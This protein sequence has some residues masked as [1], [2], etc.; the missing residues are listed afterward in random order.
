MRFKGLVSLLLLLISSTCAANHLPH[1]KQVNSHSQLIVNGQPFIMLGG[2]LGNSSATSMEY[3]QPIWPKLKTMNINTVL[4]PVYWEMIEPTPGQFDFSSLDALIGEARKQQQKLVLLWF[5]AWKNSMSS[6]APGWIKLDQ[7][8][9]PRI[10]DENGKS[11][12]ILTPFS[13]NVLDADK[14]AF[15]ALMQ[16]LKTTDTQQNTVIMVQVENEIGMLPSARDHHPLANAKFNAAVPA[17]LIHYLQ[18]PTA[19]LAPEL[20]KAWQKQ[21]NKTSG[22]WEKI[23]GKSKQTDEF[24][25]AWY[26]AD[27]VQQLAVAG[28]AVYNLPMYVNAALNRP[29]KAPG[30]YPS[31]GPLPHVMDCWKAAAPALDFLSPDFYNPRFKHWNDLYSRADNPLFIPEHKFDDTVA[32]K[33]LYAIGHYRA[34]G[35]SPF[36][37]ESTDKPEHEDLG[38]SYA[39]I[40]QLQP[41]LTDANVL[42]VDAVL[43]D[44]TEQSQNIQFGDYIFKL[45]HDFTLGWSPDAKNDNWPM[46]AAIVIQTRQNEYFIAGNGVVIN[47]AVV[48][49]DK[50][51]AGILSLQEGRFEQG[52]WHPVRQ[53]NGDQTHQG[54]HVRLPQ[55]RFGIQKLALYSYE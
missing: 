29:G 49:D 39:L 27:F 22:N 8:A 50:L 46:A 32:A 35:F 11:Q 53:L 13:A 43:F 42:K 44:K 24:F 41:M 21:G 17:K 52:N 40:K 54:R 3:M 15:V 12:E 25:M 2:E 48:K 47:F 34:L 51:N 7:K 14:A 4:T 26:Y 18:N 16:H 45:K 36:S 55:G 28:K 1:L 30:E 23:F 37:I 19:E 38:K 20:I 33:A 10:K 9:Y 6:H 5:G 31:A